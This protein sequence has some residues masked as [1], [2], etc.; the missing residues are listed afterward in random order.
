MV[1]RG[2][3]VVEPPPGSLY[4]RRHRDERTSI[5]VWCRPGGAPAN[6]NEDRTRCQR[7]TTL[8]LNPSGKNGKNPLLG[9]VCLLTT[10]VLIRVGLLRVRRALAPRWQ[11]PP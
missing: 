5:R 1:Q 8:K 4:T 9:R 3:S 7:R 10:G 2:F 11:P 6:G